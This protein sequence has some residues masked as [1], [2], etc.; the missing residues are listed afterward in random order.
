MQNTS[1]LANSDAFSLYSTLQVKYTPLSV[2]ALEGIVTSNVTTMDEAAK[3]EGRHLP[4]YALTD[5]TGIVS[6]IIAQH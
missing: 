2:T 6:E 5:S 1:T 3:N 4:I